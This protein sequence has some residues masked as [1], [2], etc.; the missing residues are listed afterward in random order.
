LCTH[1]IMNV[2]RV[3]GNTGLRTSCCGGNANPDSASRVSPVAARSGRTSRQSES[4][5]SRSC[6]PAGQAGATFDQN[7]ADRNL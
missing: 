4:D 6:V 3:Q 5:R 1:R 2:S 7:V